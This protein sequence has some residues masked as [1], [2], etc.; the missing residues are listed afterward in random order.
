MNVYDKAHELAKALTESKEYQEYRSLKEKLYSNPEQKAKIEEFEK[1]RYDAQVLAIQEGKQNEEKMQKLQ[2]LYKILV[3]N[4]D[5]KDF[6]DK[7]VF[8]NVMLADINKIIGEA[9]KDVLGW[10]WKEGLMIYLILLY[11]LAIIVLAY[12]FDYNLK[13]AK[14]FVKNDKLDKLVKNFP[15]NVEI[16]R[17]ILTMLG[18]D[19]VKI[20][21]TPNNQASF[22]IA[23][24]NKIQIGN[25]K[26]SYSRV[27]TIAH[28]CLHSCQSRRLLLFNFI[29]SN[30]YLLYFILAILFTILGIFENEYFHMCVLLLF[31]IIYIAVRGF[32]EIDAMTKAK[33][34]AQDY[35]IS[36]NICSK[37]EITQLVN[38]YE[39]MNKVGIPLIM[40]NIVI[41]CIIKIIIYAIVLLLIWQI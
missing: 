1:I 33:Y 21:E 36:N 26:D 16:C 6:F 10:F 11:L 22:Y 7:Q 17:K 2:E 9:V 34:L 35:L 41:S 24:T 8:F 29:F 28:E 14:A 39:K 40:C 19:S 31:S 5:V 23:I 30:L 12:V 13:K 37:E 38:E 32:L 3:E 15:E 25:I 4:K 20:E 18:N 27:Q